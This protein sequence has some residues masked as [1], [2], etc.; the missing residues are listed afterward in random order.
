MRCCSAC[1]LLG[2]GIPVGRR[3]GGGHLLRRHDVHLGRAFVGEGDGDALAADVVQVD[4]VLLLD[5]LA[6]VLHGHVLLRQLDLEGAALLLQFGQ[7]AALLAQGFLPRGDVRFL[8]LLLRQQ[9]GG[10]RV[11]LLAL[12]LQRLDPAAGFLDFGLGLLLAADEGGELA[13][14]L[15]D[16]LGQ[17]ADALLQGLLLLLERGAHLLLGGQ[18]HL[19][20]GQAGVGR[21]ALLA[22]RLQL[23][24]QAS[25]PATG[26]PARALPASA[27]RAAR[28][29]ALLQ[30]FLLLGGQALNFVDDRVDLLVQQALRVLQRV[31]LAFVGGDGHF[32]GAQFGLGL[33][34]AGL[35][36]GLLALQRALA[37]G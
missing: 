29:G 34:Q 28:A 9:L 22:Q 36:L 17:F 24:G 23:G 21:V 31:E 18:G 15:L 16:D 1:D 5:P 14:P 26:G 27:A 10:L 32:L 19:A 4:V 30:P 8:G 20:L 25:P 35:Q 3:A 2:H 13:A 7:A 6:Q 33:L 11:H 12:V 37:R